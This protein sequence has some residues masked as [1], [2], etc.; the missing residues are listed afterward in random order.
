[1]ALLSCTDLRIAFGGRPLLDGAS[2]HIERGERVGLVGR[3][4]E[5]KSTLL[6]IL[7]GRIAP[8]AGEVVTAS[9][10]RIAILDQR[11]PQG[12]EGTVASV[13]AEGLNPR[14]VM[15]GEGDHHV[16]RLASL[17][18]IGPEHAFE[19]L[20]GG[21][22]RRALLAR[23]LADEPD[24]LILDE[25][26]NHLDIRSILWLENFLRRWNGSLLFVTH[27]RAFLEALSTRIAELDRGQL[28]SWDCDYATYLR[29]REEQ[30]AAEEKE[31][32]R[33]DRKLAQEEAWIR[34]GIK[35][36]RTR[37]EGRV[38]A[39]Q[40]LRKERADRRG[41]VGEV[42]ME[43][44]TAERSG[45]R[46]IEAKDVHWAWDDQVIV[47]GFTTSILRGDKVGLVGPNG[48][49]KTTLLHLLLGRLE[50][51]AGTVEH[52]TRLEIAYFDQHRAQL[53]DTASVADNV[54]F[55]SD[56]VGTGADRR[57]VLSYLQDFLF[58]AERSRQPVG[59]LSG[60]ERNRLL[61]ARLFTQPANVLVLDEPTN[62]LDTE[63]LELLE[64]RLVAF[65]GTV[66]VVSHDRA[67]LDNLCTSTLVFEG[68]GVVK[69]YVGGYSDW[70]R[71]A[72]RREA[73]VRESAAGGG[74]GGGGGAG[75]D[76]RTNSEERR[77]HRPHEASRPKKLSYKEQ[78]EFEALPDRIEALENELAEV[79]AR[80]A[81]P[82]FYASDAEVIRSTTERVDS[83]EAEIEQLM[84]RWTELG[85]RVPG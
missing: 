67:F 2:L 77:R 18:E 45:R 40:R 61:L 28:T 80:L 76:G 56:H 82:E 58:S 39:L 83:L 17:L 42:R 29:R 31:W 60:G 65:D 79:H 64:S 32:E 10:V 41:R 34:Q 23:A 85:E 16:Q 47:D 20:S 73:A 38:R 8:D 71:V 11:V 53:D 36:R 59:A 62:D 51:Q 13:I 24:V 50:P 15:A 44:Q 25:P 78:R 74:A 14:L 63:T 22:K 30:L 1:M 43:I 7:A 33:Q 81:D 69:E 3:N 4:G 5:G 46:V 9:G 21:Q 26:T 57:H 6:R 68:D 72:D 70:K 55:G 84:E 49:G 54:A 27:D 48:A 75:A 66:L 19:A 12:L 52:G 37:N 35:A